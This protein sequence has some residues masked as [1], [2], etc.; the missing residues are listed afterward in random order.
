[1]APVTVVTMPNLTITLPATPSETLG[2]TS[3]EDMMFSLDEAVRLRKILD[4][5]GAC[6]M[7]SH[8]GV[9][10]ATIRKFKTQAQI[11]ELERTDERARCMWY[12]RAVTRRKMRLCARNCRERAWSI[13]TV[14]AIAAY[15]L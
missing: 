10:R 4:I 6:P 5:R 3:I 14:V 9:L 11:E 8:L 1:M 7:S 13:V 15:C 12:R 2:P